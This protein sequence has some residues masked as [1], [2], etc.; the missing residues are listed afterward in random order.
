MRVFR[1]IVAILSIFLSI[2]YGL[3]LI[4]FV[5]R[6][7]INDPSLRYF[8]YGFGAFI[9]L[10]VIWLRKAHF[11]STFEHELTH[12]LVGLLFFKKP[13]GFAVSES[14]GGITSLYGG[15]F[16]IA[17][18]PYFLPTFAYILLPFY[19]IID[20]RFHLFYFAVLGLLTSYHIFSTAQEFSYKQS[21]II[22]S[23]KVF[24]TFFLIFTNIL[25]YGFLIAFII[26]GFKEGGLF[27]KTGFFESSSWMASAIEKLRL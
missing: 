23:G 3:A 16:L 25:V 27:L 19:L 8:L 13:A 1:F 22:K 4:R 26:G 12:L 15:N 10:G 17:L 2:G 14:Q 24:S 11:F 20:P 18:A 7:N 6:L 21:D 5:P 9:P